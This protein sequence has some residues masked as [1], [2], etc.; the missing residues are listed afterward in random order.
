MPFFSY[1]V[2]C[3]RHTWFMWLV[4]EEDSPTNKTRGG[5]GHSPFI[6]GATAPSTAWCVARRTHLR[7]RKTCACACTRARN[8]RARRCTGAFLYLI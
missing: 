3:R 4:T 6:K 5:K 7:A 2:I 1:L 8:T